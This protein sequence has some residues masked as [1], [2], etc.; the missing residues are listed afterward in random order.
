MRIARGARVL[1]LRARGAT[2]GA[3]EPRGL[4]LRVALAVH[5]APETRLRARRKPDCVALGVE[6]APQ[7][8]DPAETE[9][10]VHRL[11]PGDARSAGRDAPEADPLCGGAPMMAL[12]PRPPLRLGA[13]EPHAARPRSAGPPPAALTVG[14]G[15]RRPPAWSGS[16]RVHGARS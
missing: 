9:R 4:E 5:A 16:L 10:L 2:R 8:V 7:P 11:R 14:A 3:H 13:E 1:P 15:F 12:E 6:P